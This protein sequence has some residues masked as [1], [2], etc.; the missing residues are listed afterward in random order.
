MSKK[1]L[2]NSANCFEGYNKEDECWVSGDYDY[3]INNDNIDSET[4]EFSQFHWFNCVEEF[5]N[6]IKS[7]KEKYERIYKTEIIALLLCGKKCKGK[8]VDF[9]N[10]FDVDADDIEVTIEKDD[11]L[12]IT[13]HHHRYGTGEANLYFLTE[14]NMKKSKVWNV[15]N[16]L[17]FD[18]FEYDEFEKIRNNLT[19]IKLSKNNNFYEYNSYVRN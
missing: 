6:F 18:D 17:G 14:N 3:L 11:S 10:I 19:P 5:C 7:E 16:H 2:I 4:I 8:V 1:Y 13:C 9:N 15:Y 12:L